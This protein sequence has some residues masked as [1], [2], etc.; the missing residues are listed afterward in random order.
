MPRLEIFLVSKDPIKRPLIESRK[1]T[2]VNA[3]WLK[4]KKKTYKTIAISKVVYVILEILTI[5]SS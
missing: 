3:F 2:Q 4:K 1:T 5:T